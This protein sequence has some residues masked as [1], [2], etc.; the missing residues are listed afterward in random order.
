MQGLRSL[1]ADQAK[2]AKKQEKAELKANLKKTNASGEVKGDGSSSNGDSKSSK[3]KFWNKLSAT[4]SP[5]ALGLSGSSSRR[6]SSGVFSN[7]LGGGRGG[8]G[9]PNIDGG[10]HM[11]EGGVL[12]PPTSGSSPPRA[13]SGLFGVGTG[14]MDSSRKGFS[15]DASR[16]GSRSFN[17]GGRDEYLD[18]SR[19]AGGLDASVRGGLSAAPIAR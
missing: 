1:R 10:A 13:Q 15:D 9:F 17:K 12:P 3:A 11:F 7:A 19:R 2:S 16:K 8:Q 4:S 18:L 6:S 14:V 5:G